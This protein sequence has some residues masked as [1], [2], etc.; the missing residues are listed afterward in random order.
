[1]ATD[2][3]YKYYKDLPPWAKG[4]VVV[5]SLGL[6]YIIG[7]KIY[8]ALKPKPQ[9][10]KNIESD[11]DKLKAKMSPTYSNAS[12]DNYAETIYQAQ[13]TSIGNDSGTIQDTAQLMNNDLDVALLIQAYGTRQDY[14]FGFPTEKYSLLGA[15]RKGISNDAFGVFSYR[16]G[17]INNDWKKKGITYR[18]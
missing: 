8:V 17:T 2:N 18:I 5:G 13:R 10:E 6:A 12:Y 14:A 15:M 1:M 4:I 11:I 16:I 3:I 7:S 9:D